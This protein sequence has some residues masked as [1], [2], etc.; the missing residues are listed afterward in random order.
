MA[1]ENKWVKTHT[2]EL[3]SKGKFYP[4][5]H[6]LKSGSV[7]IKAPTAAE[8]DILTSPTLAK[9]GL[10]IDK[11]VESILV[12]PVD[13]NTLLLGDKGAI[14]LAGR[15]LAY[16]PEYTFSFEDSLGEK[17]EATINLSEIESKDIDFDKYE[18]SQ[19]RFTVKL[20][21]S[22]VEVTV[23]LLTHGDDVLIRNEL[24]KIKRPI[25][26][27][28]SKFASD[29][30]VTTRLKHFIVAIRNGAEFSEDRSEIRLF[31][32]S[33]PAR[34]SLFL[35]NFIKSINPDIELV[36]TH[37]LEDGTPEVVRVDLNESFFFPS[38]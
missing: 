6:P 3:P 4:E 20:P 33:M 27:S 22:E 21:V 30:E 11:F 12:T 7:S 23:K 10:T 35:R 24:K 8:E 18:D 32:D 19:T 29:T 26:N 13:L 9:A 14:V 38:E 1:N 37:Y 34:D 17:H 5:G 15:I 16:G 36:Y 2:I 31:V 25:K 28:V